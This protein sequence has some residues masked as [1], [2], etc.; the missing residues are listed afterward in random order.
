MT[1]QKSEPCPFQEDGNPI[2]MLASCCSYRGNMAALYLFAM[3]HGALALELY[4]DKTSREALVLADDLR[5]AVKGL[6]ETMSQAAKR[7]STPVEDFL[8]SATIQVPDVGWSFRV[9]QA[10]EAI[11][12]IANYYQM[13]GMMG[14]G[15]HAWF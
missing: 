2:G 7:S 6:K 13:V 10:Y 4:A 14:F 9:E 8:A 12:D 5:T 1:H 3:G 15:V 11:E